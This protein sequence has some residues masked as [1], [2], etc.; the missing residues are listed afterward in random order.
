MV[1]KTAARSWPSFVDIGVQTPICGIAIGDS[2]SVRNY[3]Y[4]TMMRLALSFLNLLKHLLAEFKHFRRNPPLHEL[5]L[6]G[7]K[8]HECQIKFELLLILATIT[9]SNTQGDS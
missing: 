8:C 3:G 2:V 7:C 5:L 1:Y 4:N 6:L 9:S